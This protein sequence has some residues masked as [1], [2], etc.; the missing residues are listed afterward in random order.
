MC[1]INLHSPSLHAKWKLYGRVIKDRAQTYLQFIRFNTFP[2]IDMPLLFAFLLC[3]S[4]QLPTRQWFQFPI[5]Q[6]KKTQRLVRC[7]PRTLQS[8]NAKCYQTPL[9][10]RQKTN[11]QK[12][13]QHFKSDLNWFKC[14][15]TLNK[16]FLLEFCF[17]Q[18]MTRFRINRSNRN[19]TLLYQNATRL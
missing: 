3:C 8:M 12:H 19:A 10:S 4:H 15:R 16:I 18:T 2:T 7:W 17:L 9:Y 1:F 14:R 6:T 5:R 11:Y 13:F